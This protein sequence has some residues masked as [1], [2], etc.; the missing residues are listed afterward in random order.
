MCHFDSVFFSV[1]SQTIKLSSSYEM[2]CSC[3]PVSLYYYYYLCVTLKVRAL[4]IESEGSLKI[5]EV[6]L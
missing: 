2:F 6:I 4:Y 3:F 1:L 5:E